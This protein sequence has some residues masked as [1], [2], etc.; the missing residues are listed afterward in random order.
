MQINRLF[1]IV[2]ILMEKS[3]TAKELA[4][5]FEVS[6][7]TVYRDIETLCQTGI[8]IYMTRGRGGGISLMNH[9]VLDK[10]LL[11]D[12]ERQEILSAL[13]GFKVANPDIDNTLKKINTLFGM[14][15]NNWID[16]DFSDWSFMQQEKFTQLKQA[17]IDKHVIHFDY[18]NSTGKK[19]HRSAEPLQLWF[20]DRTWYLRAFCRTRQDDRVFKLTRIKNLQVSVDTF[21]RPLQ[22]APYHTAQIPP[23]DLVTLKLLI[24]ADQAY[25]VYDEFDDDDIR[26]QADGRFEVTVTYPKGA[27][28]IGYILSFGDTAEVVAPQY[29]R[30]AIQKNLQHALKKYI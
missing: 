3:V 2:Y 7:R 4:A 23:A 26:R 8:P 19:T 13:Q 28:I 12:R 24:N 10:S 25:R 6:T 5:R 15:N 21:Q 20:K 22:K 1:E 16:I 17:V 9:Y 14:Q 27:W 29:I 11:S 18:F 30:D